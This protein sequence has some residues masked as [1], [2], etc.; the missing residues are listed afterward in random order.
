MII[1][2]A[3]FV[4]SSSS[5]E[6]CPE[7]T[8]PEFAFIGRSNVGKSSLINMLVNRTG[9]AKTSAKP[10]KTRL[11]NHFL[12]NKSWYLVDLPGY[13]YASAS[14]VE[15][16][17]WSK[18]IDDY[19]SKR[20]NLACLFVLVDSRIEPQ[21]IDME[22]ISNL[23]FLGVP[24][25]LIS[26]KTDKLTKLKIERHIKSFKRELIEMREELPTH[27]ISS[28]KTATG[29]SEIL[30]LIKKINSEWNLDKT[31]KEVKT[32]K[33]VELIGDTYSEPKKEI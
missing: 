28:S 19:L 21:K 2:S 8:A 12:I 16:A 26:T 7:T 29:R 30:T 23:K 5:V 13:G 9:L 11:I 17:K 18:F 15:I 6:L 22:F 31:I 10:G 24:F 3:E 33:K 25:V 32:G 4:K 27:F 20:E 1:K 14:K